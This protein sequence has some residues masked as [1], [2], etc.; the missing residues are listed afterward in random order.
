VGEAELETL[1]AGIKRIEDLSKKAEGGDKSARAELRRAV[2]KCSPEVIADISHIAKRADAILI[3]TISAGEP[4]MEE[5]LE[6][7][8][9]YMREEM[10]GPNP[11]PLEQILSERIVSGWLLVEILEALIAAQY[12]RESGKG[13]HVSPSYIIQESK[14]LESAT[15]RY[16]QAIKTLAQVRK[17]QSATPGVQV[18]TQIN[19]S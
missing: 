9:R 2:A 6:A 10:A 16:L 7:R 19:V 3:R 18:N 4:A 12:N 15:R 5:A 11:T 14:I 1:E 13:T 17:M 8:L